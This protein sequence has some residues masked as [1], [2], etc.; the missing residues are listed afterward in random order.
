MF[1]KRKHVIFCFAD[2]AAGWLGTGAG[3]RSIAQPSPASFPD[4]IAG[5]AAWRGHPVRAWASIDSERR[6]ASAQRS[7][8]VCPR[9]GLH[10]A[11]PH[12]TTASRPVAVYDGVHARANHPPHCTCRRPRTVRRDGTRTVS[13][14]A[15]R[16]RYRGLAEHDAPVT[17]W[18]VLPVRPTAAAAQCEHRVGRRPEERENAALDVT[19]NEQTGPAP[20]VFAWPRRAGLR[21][22]AAPSRWT[23]RVWLDGQMGG[24]AAS[25]RG[26]TSAES[27]ST[28]GERMPWGK[29]HAGTI[30]CAEFRAVRARLPMPRF[31]RDS[32]RYRE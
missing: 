29:R 9:T 23:G 22:R 6:A 1:E 14:P 19:L 7:E 18:R 10:D 30:A 3:P 8:V 26:T 5:M 21:E 27:A 32:C 4:L 31:T 2:P 16:A 11:S 13:G 17:T 12:P 15:V 20:R 25:W 24:G 28:T